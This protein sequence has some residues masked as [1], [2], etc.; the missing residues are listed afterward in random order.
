MKYQLRG[1]SR[2]FYHNELQ[3]IDVVEEELP[4]EKDIFEVSKLHDPFVK[5]GKRYY[6]V[7][8]KYQR[9]KKDW[10]IEPRSSLEESVPRLL[11]L[12]EK[13][14]GV[15][16]TKKKGVWTSKGT[17]SKKATS[18]ATLRQGD[19]IEVYWKA[20]RKWFPGAVKQVDPS[21][22][23]TQV[24]YD[25]GDLKWYNLDKDGWRWRRLS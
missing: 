19:R 16:W 4:D 21:D 1:V 9:A 14:V 15:V 12:H 10:T 13:R 2:V 7:Q 6:W 5:D 20:E 17:A 24:Q 25:D 22:G 18:S 3:P 11:E 23:T 8:W